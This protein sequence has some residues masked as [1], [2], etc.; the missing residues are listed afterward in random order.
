MPKPTEK[1][2]M[3]YRHSINNVK[4]L[5]EHVSEHLHFLL[6]KTYDSKS[7]IIII[8]KLNE[9]P[10]KIT[11]YEILEKD[12]KVKLLIDTSALNNYISIRVVVKLDYHYKI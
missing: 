6:N 2:K 1:R 9:A 10:K 4:L 5:R 8:K 11:L 7:K 12:Q 3:E